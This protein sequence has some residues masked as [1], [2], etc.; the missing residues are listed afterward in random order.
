MYLKSIKAIV[1]A[2]RSLFT[3]R[4]ALLLMLAAYAGLLVAIYLFV[5]TR[6][7][8]IPQLILTFVVV[9]GAPALFF[10]WQAASV[11]YANG[12]SQIRKL[13]IDGLKLIVVSLPV[14]ALTLLALYGLNKIESHPTLVTTVRYL[15]L[16]VIA[17]LFV[18]QLWIVSSNNGLRSLIRSGRGLL[19]GTFAPQSLFV[20]ALGF[21]VFAVVPYLLLRKSFP[22]TRPWLEVSVFVLRLTASALLIFLGWVTTVG[23]LSILSRANCLSTNKV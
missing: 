1:L 15:L 20:Y 16:A 7:A 21:L 22:I 3:N 8:T 17:P 5:S 18:I 9:I 23:A 12:P 6:E 19:S 14:I 11:S 10:T 4:H 13:A 2:T